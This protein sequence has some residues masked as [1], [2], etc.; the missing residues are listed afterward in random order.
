MLWIL[1][2]QLLET[3]GQLLETFGNIWATFLSQHL[4]TLLIDNVSIS[5]SFSVSVYPC[6]FIFLSQKIKI[7]DQVVK[8]HLDQM[9]QNFL[10]LTFG[11]SKQQYFDTWFGT[12]KEVAPQQ[13]GTRIIASIANLSVQTQWPSRQKNLAKTYFRGKV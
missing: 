10:S 11:S 3:F 13:I 1:F 7:L 9:L 5:L 2:R 12:S 4:V 6:I 8:I